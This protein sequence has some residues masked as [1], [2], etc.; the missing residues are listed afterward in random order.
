MHSNQ[1]PEGGRPIRSAKP[2]APTAGVTNQSGGMFGGVVGYDITRAAPGYS[3]VSGLL[4]GFA[5]AA[6]V[7]VFTFAA[8]SGPSGHAKGDLGFATAVLALAFLGCLMSAFAF[9][10]LGGEKDS[11]QALASSMLF[12]SAV[13]VS[14]VAVL[15]GLEALAHAFLPNAHGLFMAVA[16]A[17]ALTVSPFVWFPRWEIA[18]RPS[19]EYEAA[20]DGN[21]PQTVHS[22]QQKPPPSEEH[23]QDEEMS[24]HPHRE[25]DDARRIQEEATGRRILRKVS[26]IGAAAAL[27]GLAFRLVVGGDA[28]STVYIPVAGVAFGYT[29]SAVGVGLLTSALA[30]GYVGCIIRA[31]PLLG[32]MQSLV[33]F[34]LLVALR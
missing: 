10:S 8:T 6:V 27:A 29:M 2:G 12:G 16:F 25:C 20:P 24:L 30:P 4:S 11:T 9:A 3:N 13:A 33:I 26:V 21:G 28:S 1:D 19:R 5:L 18:R 31:T 22:S 34:G 14:V 32:V 7:L 17:A 23:R 15:D